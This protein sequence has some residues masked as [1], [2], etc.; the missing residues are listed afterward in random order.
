MPRPKRTI[1]PVEKHI[2][3]PEDIVTKIELELWSD[4][5]GRV[6]FGAWSQLVV[7]LLEE[8]LKRKGV[9]K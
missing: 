8:H 5:E 6:P 7:G 9:G 4:L 3:I 2:S 1:R